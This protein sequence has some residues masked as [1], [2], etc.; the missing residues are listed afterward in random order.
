M[1]RIQAPFINTALEVARKA[2]S[3]DGADMSAL[4]PELRD[5]ILAACRALDRHSDTTPG[6]R[7]IVDL[8]RQA[9][10]NRPMGPENPGDGESA[11]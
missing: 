2:T 9:C 4:K 5:A 3:T 6:I 7:E 11:S 1:P 10:G 8:A